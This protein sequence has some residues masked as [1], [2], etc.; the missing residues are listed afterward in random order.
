MNDAKRRE[1]LERVASTEAKIQASL[2]IMASSVHDGPSFRY[3]LESVF[4]RMAEL[5]AIVKESLEES[6]PP[7]AEKKPN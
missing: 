4:E 7:E 1:L 2:P 3:L 6:N 5:T